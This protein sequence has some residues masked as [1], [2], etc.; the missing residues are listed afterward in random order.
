M[1]FRNITLVLIGDFQEKIRQCIEKSCQIFK[2]SLGSRPLSSD[3]LKRFFQST[4]DFLSS[5]VR[6][7]Y[8][9]DRLARE[10]DLE[11]QSIMNDVDVDQQG[12]D[13]VTRLVQSFAK[14]DS[15][16]LTS[17]NYKDESQ[18]NNVSVITDKYYQQYRGNAKVT[19]TAY[20]NQSTI[21]NFEN[22][23]ISNLVGT[24]PVDGNHHRRTNTNNFILDK[25]QEMNNSIANMTISKDR[26]LTRL[27]PMVIDDRHSIQSS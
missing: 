19:S 14:P 12:L 11:W 6:D 21:D 3:Q 27:T 9:K 13:E 16:T 17:S 1:V 25:V 15:S 8:A 23:P 20:N 22:S 2:M 5:N 18:Q 10:I 7:S 4:F 26:P 24:K